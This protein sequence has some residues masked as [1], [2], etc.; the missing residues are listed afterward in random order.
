[1]EIRD[2]IRIAC[3]SQPDGRYVPN[4]SE[5][6]RLRQTDS[7]L[8]KHSVDGSGFCY[9][10]AG[11]SVVGYFRTQSKDILRVR[12]AEIELVRKRFPDSSSVVL[13]IETS[14]EQNEAGFFFWD[15]NTLI[16]FS[17]KSFPFDT[18][19]LQGATG[20]A[21]RHPEP[22]S[23]GVEELP[24]EPEIDVKRWQT[25][26]LDIRTRWAAE[27][28]ILASRSTAVACP[29]SEEVLLRPPAWCAAGCPLLQEVSSNPSA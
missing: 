10:Y 8:E 3:E 2:C 12:D 5:L 13:L 6:E 20:Q 25:G 9:W 16:P 26:N 27:A 29:L 15:P 19:A 4:V 23:Q 21:I 24:P 1:V 11:L 14:R 22:A 17:F 18:A 28:M 7:G